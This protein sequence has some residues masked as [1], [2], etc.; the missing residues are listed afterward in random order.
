M[1]KK[2]RS[3]GSKTKGAEHKSNRVV[4]HSAVLIEE[5]KRNPVS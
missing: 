1:E 3:G 4:A 2:V 5:S